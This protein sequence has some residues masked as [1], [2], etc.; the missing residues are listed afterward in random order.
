MDKLIDLPNIGPVLAEELKQV[1]I[2]TPET[3]REA[4]VNEEV[5]AHPGAKSG[6]AGIF[7]E[8]V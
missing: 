3:L 1:G 7:R 8:Y 4:R 6:A 2:D 5:P